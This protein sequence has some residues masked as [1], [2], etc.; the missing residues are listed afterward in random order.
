MHVQRLP[1]GVAIDLLTLRLVQDCRD[2]DRE[3]NDERQPTKSVLA[4]EGTHAVGLGFIRDVRF[5][6]LI[7]VVL[8]LLGSIYF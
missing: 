8:I 7:I 6:S 2:G 1:C 4:I 5:A 3:G